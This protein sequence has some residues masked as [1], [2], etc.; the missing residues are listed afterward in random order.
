M[1][2]LLLYSLLSLLSTPLFADFDSATL[3]YQ[4]RDY[5]TAFAEFSH[6]ANNGDPRAQ[7]VLALMYTFGEGTQADTSQAL[8]WY[9]RAAAAG[10]PAAQYYLASLYANGSGTEVDM[11]LAISW[12]QKSAAGGFE[13]AIERL[14]ALA[15]EPQTPQ[16]SQTKAS[17]EVD[18][19]LPLNFHLPEQWR[20]SSLPNPSPVIQGYR[21]QLGAF[22]SSAA[23]IKFWRQLEHKHA[24]LVAALHVFIETTQLQQRQIHRVQ[25]GY[26][27]NL[28][29]IDAFCHALKEAR[30]EAGC[31]GLNP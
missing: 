6:L 3:A 19:G 21:V 14:Q 22:R 7:T 29:A 23:A 12:L 16:T 1:R 13:R 8:Q 2:P 28:T 20:T 4:Q 31:L 9:Q 11:D 18:Q 5:S 27:E 15:I 17:T 10:Y 24:D 30:V 26:F 25:V